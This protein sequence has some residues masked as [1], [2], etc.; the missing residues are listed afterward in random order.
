MTDWPTDK[1]ELGYLPVYRKLA[2]ELLSAPRILEVGVAGGG[3]MAMFRDVF[4]TGM[5]YGVDIKPEA[6][7]PEDRDSIITC[8]QDD[9][10]LP[11]VLQSNGWVPFDLIVDDAS[12]LAGPTAVTLANLWPL[13][14]PGGAYVIEDWNYF[15]GPGMA[16]NLWQKLIGWMLAHPGVG[17]P[18]RLPPYSGMLSDVDSVTIRDGMIIVRRK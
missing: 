14:T 3:G 18:N 7:Q 5:V 1:V 12:H 10:G 8:S 11:L 13:V 2:H 6:G 17:D 16:S 15:E 9:P 4:D